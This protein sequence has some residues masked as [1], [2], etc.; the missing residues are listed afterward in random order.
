MQGK[1]VL[2]TGA[3]KGIGKETVRALA[4]K[5]AT[6]IMACR[7]ITRSKSVCEDIRNESGNPQIELMRLDL[8][9]LASIREFSKQ[10][11]RDY[12]QLNVLINNAGVFCMTRQE[13]QD[14]FEKTMGTNY[15]G[16]FFLTNSLLPVIR[17]TS[18]ARIINVSS[19][20]NFH[21]RI[22]LTNLNPNNKYHGF[23]A[24]AA[25]KLAIVLFTLELAERLNGTGITV[26][27]LRPGHTYTD[28]WNI[29][30]EKWYQ[31]LITRIMRC[32]MITPE[33][34]AES[35]IY[36]ASSNEVQGITGRYYDRGKPREP[37]AK[38]RDIQLR[39]GLWQLSEKLTGL[40]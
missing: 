6:I 34:G 14:G 24:Y 13:T 31:A 12:Q 36:L 39:R 5:D 25:S 22:D 17:R 26:N 15:L 29:W 16:Q 40:A 19:N 7:D 3:N 1:V 11:A 38:W 27:A 37:S 2:I 21:G 33:E 20:A 30:P 23:R 10:F 9:S 8:A 32:F 4:R 18:E 28:I 35:I